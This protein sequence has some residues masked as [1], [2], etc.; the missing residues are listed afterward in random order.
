MAELTGI[1]CCA[2]LSGGGLLDV[3]V[4]VVFVDAVVAGADDEGSCNADA[5]DGIITALLLVTALTLETAAGLVNSASDVF[6]LPPLAGLGSSAA[7]I[8]ASVLLFTVVEASLLSV[9]ALC[10]VAGSEGDGSTVAVE[11]TANASVGEEGTD[12]D[13]DDGEAVFVLSECWDELLQTD[14]SRRRLALLYSRGSVN[15]VVRLL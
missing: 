11:A 12:A 4:V 1:L 8:S 2:F 14:K 10:S 6:S 9:P 5:A 3:V 15:C 7:P 13:K